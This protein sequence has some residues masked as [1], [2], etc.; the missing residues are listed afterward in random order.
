[1]IDEPAPFPRP[2][3]SRLLVLSQ[4]INQPPAA[5]CDVD[6]HSTGLLVTNS[7]FLLDLLWGF[8]LLFLHFS[9]PIRISHVSHFLKSNSLA[10]G[11]E[12]CFGLAVRLPSA[13]PLP[14]PPACPCPAL[15]Q[16]RHHRHHPTIPTVSA[17]ATQLDNEG[18][19]PPWIDDITRM[20]KC[21]ENRSTVKNSAG[22]GTLHLT[23][24]ISH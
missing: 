23:I 14:S 12:T 2:F 13:P 8:L 22:T 3:F 16:I 21:H 18:G 1:M 10:T 15:H 19:C 6:R 9:A 7:V 11:D 5:S 17:T 20:A 24:I 4:L